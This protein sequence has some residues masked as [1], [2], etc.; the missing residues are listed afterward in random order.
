[1]AT[2]KKP[3]T[4]IF[5]VNEATTRHSVEAYKKC[6]AALAALVGTDTWPDSPDRF[7]TPAAWFRQHRSWHDRATAFEFRV[8]G[9][10]ARMTPGMVMTTNEDMGVVVLSVAHSLTSTRITIFPEDWAVVYASE[11]ECGMIRTT[12]DAEDVPSML[13]VTVQS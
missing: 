1:M 5:H 12:G 11:F 7:P 6:A 4:P 3:I 8:I 13:I 9:E 10:A 2:K